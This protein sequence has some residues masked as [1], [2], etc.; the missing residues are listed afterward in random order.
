MPGD[1]C[2]GES[3][4]LKLPKGAPAGV[5]ARQAVGLASVGMTLEDFKPMHYTALAVRAVL[6]EGRG[7]RRPLRAALPPYESN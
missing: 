2:E 3:A 6:R 7:M 1:R 4:L 5:R